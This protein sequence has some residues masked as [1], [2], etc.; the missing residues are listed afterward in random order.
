MGRVVWLK[1]LYKRRHN[2]A[3]EKVKKKRGGEFEGRNYW[4]GIICEEM[5][6]W[7]LE[8]D[9]EGISNRKKKWSMK[10]KGNKWRKKN[11][12]MKS[13]EEKD[14]FWQQP[15]ISPLFSLRDIQ[16]YVKWTSIWN[17]FGTRSE[18]AATWGS[19]EQV[20]EHNEKVMSHSHVRASLPFPPAPQSNSFTFV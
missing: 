16:K 13:G 6:T 9:K 3:V 20:E 7:E 2:A 11:R 1:E 15:H 18:A 5:K 4:N 14:A 17:P 12:Q 19:L 10:W 8:Q